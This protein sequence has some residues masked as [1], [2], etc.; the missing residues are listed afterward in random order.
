MNSQPAPRKPVKSR[1]KLGLVL[2]LILGVGL[3]VGGCLPVIFHFQKKLGEES[4]AKQDVK[5]QLELANS[6]N[7][8]KSTTIDSLN[9][10]ISNWKKKFDDESIERQRLAQE[11][12][13]SENAFA[14]SEQL[15]SE[16]AMQIEQQQGQI[17]DL[18]GANNTLREEK[19]DLQRENQ[20]LAADLKRSQSLVSNLRAEQ[21]RSPRIPA[22]QQAA[23]KDGTLTVERMTEEVTMPL[24]GPINTLR[25]VDWPSKKQDDR[26]CYE[27]SRNGQKVTLY[28][29]QVPFGT[30]EH[31]VL[32]GEDTLVLNWK[33]DS[34]LFWVDRAQKNRD[35]TF[36]KQIAYQLTQSAIAFLYE[37]KNP[38]REKFIGFKFISN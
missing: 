5:R 4:V 12:E 36:E 6:T 26:F 3:T 11:L 16:R 19:D 21:D 9:S 13:Q 20:T 15:N 7:E 27:S 30:I 8:E 28:F 37:S 14:E 22:S 33:D 35:V 18:N 2:G 23:Q 10:D 38:N 34:P 17:A 1:F 25:L 24:D 29:N 31:K 32:K